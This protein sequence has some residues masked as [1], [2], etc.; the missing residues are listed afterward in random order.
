MNRFIFWTLFP[1]SLFYMSVFIPVPYYFDYYS[2]EIYFEIRQY[3]CWNFILLFQDCS[4][5][6]GSFIFP[7]EFKDFFFCFCEKYLSV[8]GIIAILTKLI[9]LVDE[10]K[11]YFHLL[12]SL[13]FFHLC[14]VF[15]NIEIFHLHGYIYS[16]VFY[17]FWKC[18][19]VQSYPFMTPWTVAHQDPLSMEFPR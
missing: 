17:C 1:V 9:L 7:Y 13:I 18:M 16:Q 6:S 11:I 4:D 10:H 2:F 3:N 14:F 19:H 15:F 5:S 12:I 8:M